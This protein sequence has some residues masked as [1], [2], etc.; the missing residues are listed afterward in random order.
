MTETL[1]YV[2]Y[3]MYSDDGTLASFNGVL[4]REDNDYYYVTSIIGSMFV[5]AVTPYLIDDLPYY[6]VDKHACQLTRLPHNPLMIPFPL[7]KL[8]SESYTAEQWHH[9]GLFLE[10]F[11]YTKEKPFQ[12]RIDTCQEMSLLPHSLQSKLISFLAIHFESSEGVH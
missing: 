5:K 10:W 7:W 3:D 4:L 1:T 9:I 6:T 12:A 8:A 11:L 2:T